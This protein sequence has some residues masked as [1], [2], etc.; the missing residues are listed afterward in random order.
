MEALALFFRERFNVLLEIIKVIIKN[1]KF[2]W[3]AAAH[4]CRSYSPEPQTV[5]D[6]FLSSDSSGFALIKTVTSDADNFQ[7]NM[8]SY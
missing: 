1:M 8:L 4:F 7:E 2:H 6:S 5:L 3:H